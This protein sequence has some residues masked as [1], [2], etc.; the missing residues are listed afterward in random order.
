MFQM[1]FFHF[2]VSRSVPDRFQIVSRLGGPLF[3]IY[4]LFQIFRFPKK[5]GT[6]YQYPVPDSGKDFRFPDCSRF[7]NRIL[8]WLQQLLSERAGDAGDKKE[9]D[10]SSSLHRCRCTRSRRRLQ[11]LLPPS[12]LPSSSSSITIPSS[13]PPPPPQS[14]PSSSSFRRHCRRSSLLL[15]C[16]RRRH[17]RR[18]CR[19]LSPSPSPSPSLPQSPLSLPLPSP[20]SSSFLDD[21]C[22]CL[23]AP[24]L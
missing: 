18:R 20:L 21:C 3:Q 11:Q 7:W 1:C 9:K 10:S 4:F 19:P 23:S 15:L 16:R 14:P 13:S 6:G 5:S 24:A 12:P 2:F 22:L 8:T 17:R